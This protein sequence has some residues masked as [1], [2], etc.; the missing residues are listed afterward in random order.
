VNA[1]NMVFV[2]ASNELGEFRAGMSAAVFGAVSAVVIGGAGTVAVAALWAR[3]FPDLR[4]ARHL[5]GR[6]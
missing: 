6:P 1:V 2:G 4:R 5:D 3:F